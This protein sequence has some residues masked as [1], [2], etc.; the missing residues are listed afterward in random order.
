MWGRRKTTPEDIT[1]TKNTD[2]TF[3]A[4]QRLGDYVV[5]RNLSLSFK[6]ILRSTSV[7]VQGMLTLH[8]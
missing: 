6:A 2:A 7:G 4:N 3:V 8:A 1:I 5:L